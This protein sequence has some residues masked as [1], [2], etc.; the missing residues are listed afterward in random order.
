MNNLSIKIK[1]ILLVLFSAIALAVV[2]LVG[3]HGIKQTADSID[4]IA[5]N[6]LPSILGLNMIKDG[7][8]ALRYAN[9][10][11]TFYETN[12]NA[13]EKFAEVPKIKER[14]WPGLEQ[15]WK[16]Y[17][18]ILH[19]PEEAEAW[20]AFAAAFDKWKDSDRDVA[21]TLTALSKNKDVE[22]QKQLFVTIYRQIET[23]SK[24]FAETESLLNKLLDF[25]A[26]HID[27]DH[28][29]SKDTERNARNL[30]IATGSIAAIIA[31]LLGVVL[32]RSITG[33][34]ALG[35]TVARKIAEGDL[36]SS[37]SVDRGDEI[38][39]LLGSLQNMQNVLKNVVVDIEDIV[40]AAV[41]GDFSKQIDLSNHKGFA[42]NLGLALNQLS[43]TTNTGLKDVTR[44]ADA[45][46]AGDLSQRITRDYPGVFGQTKTGVNNTVDA[47]GKIM[48]EI[49]H[50][51]D[52]A[53]NRGDF[54][55]KLDMYGKAGYTRTLSEQLNRLSEV[56]ETGL[57]DVL[58]VANA[59]S[60]GDLTQT[61]GSDYPGIF[62]KVKDG[63][64]ATVENLKNMVVEIKNVTDTINTASKEIAA[65]NN[66]LSHR[67]EEQATSLEQTAASMEELT[68]A[69]KHNSENAKQ[70]NRL[71]IGASD[72]AGKGVAVV[73]KVIAT[74]N[75]INESSRKIVDIISVI[76]SIAFQTNILAL[77]AAVEAA[78]AGEQGRGFA[79]V[80]GEVRNLAQR[81]AIAAGEI[82]R[83]IG[84]SEEKAADGSA[85]VAQAGRTMEDIVGSINGVTAIMAQISAASVEQ[86]SGISQVNLAVAQ[87]DDVTQ[88]NAALV[89][90]A[91]AA[92]E[93]LEEQVQHLAA[94]VDVFKME[95]GLASPRKV[96]SAAKE[97]TRV[98]LETY[99]SK[100]TTAAKQS[101]AV[102]AAESDDWSVF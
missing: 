72:V 36:S 52:A 67:T 69:V 96:G 23:Q 11:A 6:R 83:L 37:I 80:A 100:N 26:Q 29:H 48:G 86:S 102:Q 47:L 56:N 94:T 63:I 58:R 9:A 14:I 59:L 61:I 98:K 5:D 38:G 30:M 43:E 57:N 74:M 31:L 70:A 82:K 60:K 101:S 91:A 2:G 45:L 62:G 90:Q 19:E 25:N 35:I 24:F 87:M 28:M 51:V 78:R 84:D 46:A 21:A 20:Q 8:I 77:N 89:E 4:S 99:K 27:K 53:A 54:S 85:L 66:N 95:G 3:N 71:A 32:I 39:Q 50:L 75:N 92:A 79:V 17:A 41:K 16:I 13:Q 42:Q 81:A 97:K 7:Q 49:Q 44:V 10:E 88:Q 1:L 76:D 34:L 68:S 65:G 22:V 15:G 40:G 55:V 93:S 73:H 18:D 64:N 33:P 12:Y